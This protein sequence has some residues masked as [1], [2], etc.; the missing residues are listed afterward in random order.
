MHRGK[1]AIQER[2]E[3]IIQYETLLTMKGQRVWIVWPDGRIN[4]RWWTV[5]GPEWNS[6]DFHRR[7][8]YGS[9]WRAYAVETH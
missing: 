8:D 4:A 7:R 1:S 3:A 2:G 5:G 6:M 9:V